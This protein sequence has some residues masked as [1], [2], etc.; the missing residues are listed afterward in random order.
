MYIDAWD[1]L[2]FSLEQK[3]SLCGNVE[4]LILFQNGIFHIFLCPKCTND[5]HTCT[6]PLSLLVQT[7]IDTK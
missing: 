4:D 3:C 5:I 2:G 7:G 1:G 6:A